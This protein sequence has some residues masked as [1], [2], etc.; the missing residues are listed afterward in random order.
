MRMILL[1]ASEL[2]AEAILLAASPDRVRMIV[3]GSDDAT[4]LRLI[5]D[6]WM[7]EEDDA[8]DI[9]SLII[10]GESSPQPRAHGNAA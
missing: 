4:E 6:Q 5:K 9:Q 10:C 3:R 1:Y 7:T 2:R 8:V